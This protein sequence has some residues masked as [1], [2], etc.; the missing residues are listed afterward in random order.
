MGVSLSDD[1]DVTVPHSFNNFSE[2]GQDSGV[3]DMDEDHNQPNTEIALHVTTHGVTGAAT[4]D[5]PDC[6][7][8]ATA[9]QTHQGRASAGYVVTYVGVLPPPTR[10]AAGVQ[11]VVTTPGEV[12]IASSPNNNFTGEDTRENHSTE[13]ASTEV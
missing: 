13:N 10:T 4:T 1:S 9:S 12:A 11:L 5:L 2:G 8:T 6:P 3:Q 7:I